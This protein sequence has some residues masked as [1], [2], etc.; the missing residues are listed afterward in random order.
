MFLFLF[1]LC[2]PASAAQITNF[3]LDLSKIN[4]NLGSLSG[5]DDMSFNHAGTDTT[6]IKQD[7]HTTDGGSTWTLG[8]GDTFTESLI[9]QITGFGLNDGS[10]ANSFG[11]PYID[12]YDESADQYYTMYIV[13][14]GLTGHINNYDNRGTSNTSDDTWDYVFDTFSGDLGIYLD[15]LSNFNTLKST[16]SY[17][18]VN[19]SNLGSNLMTAEVIPLSGGTADGYIGGSDDQSNYSVSLEVTGDGIA[20]DIWTTSEGVELWDEYNGDLGWLLASQTGVASIE[21]GDLIVPN[22]AA[23]YYLFKGK[24]GD[25][26]KLEAVPEPTTMLL[27]G[28]GLIG[29]ASI[30]GRKMKK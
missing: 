17:L 18:G 28:I 5:I 3:T 26:L 21:S 1:L 6:Q 20:D 30:S 27:F 8:D 13:A 11:A 12:N 10:T 29:L 9:M 16:L 23:P 4:V 2:S 24:T 14:Q 25:I 19:N 22:D 15:T 7:L